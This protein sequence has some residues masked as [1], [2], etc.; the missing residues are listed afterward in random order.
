MSILSDQKQ[1]EISNILFLLKDKGVRF[2]I[3][4]YS[5]G[6]DSGAIDDIEYYSDK[7]NDCVV[8]ISTDLDSKVKSAL[9]DEIYS[10]LEG[11]DDWYNNEGGYGE[12]KLDLDTLKYEID[13]NV[14]YTKTM[15]DHADGYFFE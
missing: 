13:N 6:G 4:N 14:Y 3:V 15:S 2:L 10:H 11:V 7:E 8:N 5:G 9:E 1:I 12:Y